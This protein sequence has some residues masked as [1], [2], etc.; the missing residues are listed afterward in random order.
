MLLQ[1]QTDSQYHLVAYVSHSLIV[2][3]HNYHSTKQEFLVLKWAIMKQ[4]QEYLLWK[5]FVVKTDNNL[6]IYIMTTP[7]L[8]APQ[9][10][11]V[12]SLAGLTFSIEYQKGWDNAAADALSQVTLRLDAE[13]VKSI[14]DGVAMASTGRADAH[15]PMVA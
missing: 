2:H 6:F 11:W 13:T 14:L 4:F 7:N 1:K 12:E 15:D 5:S 8:D 9:H 3:E 10:H